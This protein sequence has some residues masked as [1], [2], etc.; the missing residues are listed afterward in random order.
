[1]SIETDELGVQVV[2]FT[3]LRGAVARA[4]ADA[5]GNPQVAMS[6]EVNVDACL[7]ARNRM[8]HANGADVRVSLT[9]FVLRS[10]GLAL[11]SHPSMCG[12]VTE[13]GVEL[14]SDVD[15]GV[16]VSV[17]DG[18]LVPVVRAVDAK[19]VRAIAQEAGRL[20]S[21]AR[22]GSLGMR[23]MRGGVFTVSVL[24][25]TGIDWFT[26]IVSSPQ[27]AILGV[28]AA[29]PRPVVLDGRVTVATTASFTLVFDHRAVD[30]QPA[31]LF[32]ATVRDL[33]ERPAD[34]L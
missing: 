13:A 21:A 29:A 8:R 19:A 20:V 4:V 2:P 10:V 28:G 22:D 27:V 7:A 12:R 5:W 32:L 6:V 25:A 34:L 9:H 17:D 31:A 18:I 14:S 11:R 1:M 23:D 33:I 26:P 3:G 16:A 24:G 15:V 30:G